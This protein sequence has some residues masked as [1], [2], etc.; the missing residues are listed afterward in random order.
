MFATGNHF[1]YDDIK[2]GC[3]K[4]QI[5]YKIWMRVTESKRHILYMA[6]ILQQLF[7]YSV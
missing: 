3:C 5:I 7:H 4:I 6:D 2:K 1:A